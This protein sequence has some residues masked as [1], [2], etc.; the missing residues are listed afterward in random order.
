MQTVHQ[1]PCDSAF[2]QDPYATYRQ[3]RHE[4]LLWWAEYGMPVSARFEVVNTLLRDRRFGREAPSGCVPERPAHL[5]PFYDFE[6]RSMLEREPPTHTRLRSLVLRAF[7]S[8]RIE[9]LEGEV[10]SLAH[11][12]IDAFPDGPFDLLPALAER[13]PVIVIARMIGV[14]ESM[15]PQLLQWSHDMVGMYQAKRDRAMEDRAVAATLAFSEYIRSLAEVR[16]S[17][18]GH[19][20]IS[21]LLAAEADG[22]KLSMDELITTVVLLLNA[23]HE[24]TVHAIGNGINTLLEHGVWAALNADTLDGMVEETLRF[25]PPLHMFTRYALQDVTLE[26]G[27]SFKQGETIGLMLAA[28]NRDPVRFGQANT[29]D[30]F[31][32]DGQNVSFG[33]GIHFCI[34]A[35]LARLEME[36]ALPLLFQRLPRLA[37]AE[38]PR[39]HNAYH[40]HGLESLKVRF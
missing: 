22:D 26:N 40:F 12:L 33:A 35:P 9:A 1:H 38:T 16:R 14:P 27:L 20:L 8:R 37:L 28:D 36:V 4:P 24:A 10:L 11:Q 32:T 30:P 7:T 2:V 25:D 5:K 6:S 3:W 18:P 15:A 23:G 39:Y 29:F 21:E 17:A 31:R 34:G 13:V 19:D